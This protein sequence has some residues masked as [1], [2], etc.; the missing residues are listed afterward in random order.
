[1][2]KEKMKLSSKLRLWLPVV[3]MIIV[4]VI[5]VYVGYHWEHKP[6]LGRTLKFMTHKEELTV[7]QFSADP[8]YNRDFAW[9]AEDIP[10][11]MVSDCKKAFMRDYDGVEYSFGENKIY[12][13]KDFFS[14]DLEITLNTD[15]GWSMSNF[16]IYSSGENIVI[17]GYWNDEFRRIT[18]G[19]TQESIVKDVLTI[20]PGVPF[21]ADVKYISDH[22]KEGYIFVISQDM[23]TVSAYKEKSIVGEKIVLPNEIL[24]FYDGSMI[25][26]DSDND[27][28]KLYIPYIVENNG[29]EEVICQEVAT[30]TKE[31]IEH[32][33]DTEY[34]DDF[35]SYTTEYAARMG[36]IIC[37]IFENKDG[38]IRMIVPNDIQKYSAYRQGTDILKLEDD[39]GWHWITINK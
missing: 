13:E 25:L 6:V 31:E 34:M 36:G 1:M 4:Y 38:K 24:G 27:T 30:V 12:V 29:K 9:D 32:V 7:K 10:E 2:G 26:A 37:Y 39:L 28:D 19:K 22:I 5:G 18:L 15:L 16:S 17:Y 21:S 3:A 14:D 23:R 11:F 8:I 20:N 35:Y 33:S